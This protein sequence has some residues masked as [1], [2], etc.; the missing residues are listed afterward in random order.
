MPSAAP[1]RYTRL[2]PDQHAEMA[3]LWETGLY[4]AAELAHRFGCSRRGVQAA[5][6]RLG[7]VKGAAPLPSAPPAPSAGFC[8]A[9]GPVL[10]GADDA[11]ARQV[12]EE[13]IRAAREAAWQH[14]AEL[15][16]MTMHA[17][18]TLAAQPPGATTLRALDL[19]ASVMGRVRAL[20][21]ASLGLDGK[22]PVDADDLPEL[23]I[24]EMTREEIAAIRARQAAEDAELAGEP[25]PGGEVLEDFD[26]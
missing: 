2:T 12:Q 20:R 23:P 1:R 15:E 24:R 26:P 7:A 8:A 9:P 25:P 14:A 18:R 22:L 4:T 17:A 13:R 10:D 16:A 6:E 3:R 21:W 11:P 5:L 19:A